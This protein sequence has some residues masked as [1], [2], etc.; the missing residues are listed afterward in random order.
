M[1]RRFYIQE[2][3]CINEAF[4][5][6]DILL[7]AVL[8]SSLDVQEAVV[9]AKWFFSFHFRKNPQPVLKRHWPT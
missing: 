4:F 9:F 3:H 6:L 7:H 5:F 8:S 2:Y 1:L